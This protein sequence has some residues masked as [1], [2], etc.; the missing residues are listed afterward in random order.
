MKD[1]SK[2]IIFI[3]LL[4]EFLLD[5]ICFILKFPVACA[6]LLFDNGDRNFTAFLD[7]QIFHLNKNIDFI[8]NVF[9]DNNK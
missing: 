1:N 4:W 3:F 7:Y 8:L 9:I 5:L 2:F 6:F